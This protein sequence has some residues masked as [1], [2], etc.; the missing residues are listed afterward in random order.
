M[1]LC[2]GKLPPCTSMQEQNPFRLNK[3]LWASRMHRCPAGEDLFLEASWDG[4]LTSSPALA[5]MDMRAHAGPQVPAHQWRTQDSPRRP[6]PLHAP[7]RAQTLALNPG[8]SQGTSTL[9]AEGAAVGCTGLSTTTASSLA[10]TL[11]DPCNTL[12]HNPVCEAAQPS[13]TGALASSGWGTASTLGD[14][15]SCSMATTA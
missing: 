11:S 5:C 14:T 1:P 8:L 4:S 7:Q 6:P 10:D 15:S 9:A 3:P 2:K 12:G 13:M